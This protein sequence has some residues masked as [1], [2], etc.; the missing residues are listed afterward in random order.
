MLV[1]RT[2]AGFLL[3]LMLFSLFYNAVIWLH[4]ELYKAEITELFCVNKD[5]PEM[6]CNGKCHVSKELID[7][8]VT[9]NVPERPVREASYVPLLERYVMPDYLTTLIRDNDQEMIPS[10][11]IWFWESLPVKPPFHPPRA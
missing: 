4:Y 7:F 10:F 9:P 5:K 1:R 8:N 6:H 2:I 11:Y 3:L